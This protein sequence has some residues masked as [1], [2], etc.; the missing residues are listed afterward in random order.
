M[1]LEAIGGLGLFLL[2]MIVMTDGLKALAGDSLRRTLIRFTRS[3]WSG[4][5]TGAAST[6]LLQS[7]SA[8]TVA[9]VGFVA[10][11]LMSFPLALGVIFGANV[12]TTFTGWIVALL[13]LKLELGTVALPLVFVGAALRLFG[14]G[15]LSAVGFALA[16][17][18]LIFV[19]ITTM[20][21]GM[22]GMREMFSFDALPGD[23]LAGRL[24]LVSVGIAFTVVA[25]SSSAGVAATLTALF[26]G[27]IEFQQAAALVIGMDVG[28]TV[29]AAL[30]TVGAATNARRTGYSH[31]IFNLMT[32]I[33]ALLLL[34]PYFLAWEIVAPG[35][36]QAHAELALVG[37]HTTFNTVG[38]LLA[39]PFTRPFT[40]L[41]ERI[42]PG[43][44]PTYT[45]T[46][47]PALLHDAGLALPAA[48]A[49]VRLEY[50]SALRHVNA[51][52]N[53]PA[54]EQRV[55]LT[56]LQTALDETHDYIDRIH[57]ERTESERWR[58]LTATIH[59]LDHLQRLHE[60]CEEERDRAVAAAQTPELAVRVRMVVDSNR[61]IIAAVERNAW[62]EA[63][64]TARATQDAVHEIVR[65][66]RDSVM[67]QI[68]SG[69]V[70]V[71]SGTS[72][73]EA[74]RWLRR[75]SKH[76]ARISEHLA[77]AV[78]AVGE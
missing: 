10:A 70:D 23:T 31:V 78:G 34:D 59:A 33:G 58:M 25:Q 57:L 43:A 29:T 74:M 5:A 48:I 11:G 17:F 2:G 69:H 73:L 32:G 18:G 49:S 60:R 41:M 27:L 38:T 7:S 22:L 72:R 76:V 67:Q 15:R 47:D 65:E 66:F 51:V 39:L 46:L 9:T 56:E 44:A 21:N 30:A 62:R 50:Q 63:A 14:Q 26:S 37:F 45:S 40:R 3:P 42:V 6:A 36:L 54:A 55:D 19:G 24:A 71:P 35:Q 64:K 12:G 52:L 1:L 16:G 8:T 77:E 75:V 68:A 4:A 28:T 61:A 13:G 53:A 20:Q